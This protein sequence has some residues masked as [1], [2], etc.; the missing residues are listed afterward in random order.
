SESPPPEY[1]PAP[2]FVSSQ[3]ASAN[4]DINACIRSLAVGDPDEFILVPMIH[5]V[6]KKSFKDMILRDV[7]KVSQTVIVRKM[8]RS[9]YL[10]F[11]AKD[12]DGNYIGTE[13]PAADAGLVFVPSKSTPEEILAQVHKVAFGKLHYAAQDSA[14]G[15]AAAGVMAWS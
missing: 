12:I 5:S 15:A 3:P 4:Q 14:G 7:G 10:R 6:E 9:H 11:Y 8:R 2:A 13:K 1:D